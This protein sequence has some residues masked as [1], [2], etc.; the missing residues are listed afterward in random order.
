M[1][2]IDWSSDVCSSDLLAEPHIFQPH[3]GKR[4]E[5]ILYVA[6]AAEEIQ[7]FM[8]GHCQHIVYGGAASQMLDPDLENFRPETLAVAIGTA[9]VHIRQELHFDMLKTGSAEIGRASC[10][11]RVCQYV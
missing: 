3:V 2:I 1:R 4:Q 11:E 8:H 7:G 6:Q 9:Q 10:R 5:P